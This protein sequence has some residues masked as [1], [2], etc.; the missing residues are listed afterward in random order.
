ML[1]KGSVIDLVVATTSLQGAPSSED[2]VG[3]DAGIIDGE[4]PA[5]GPSLE[6]IGGN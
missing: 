1:Q 6:D 4:L 3:I 5:D 2:S